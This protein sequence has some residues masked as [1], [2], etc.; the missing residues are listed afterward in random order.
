MIAEMV[1]TISRET[2]KESLADL[3]RKYR[4][5]LVHVERMQGLGQLPQTKVRWVLRNLR[6]STP[7]K[8][9]VRAVVPF[10]PPALFEGFEPKEI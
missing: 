2:D 8:E 7:E 3:A 9:T 1:I 6:T 5:M 4:L 10:T